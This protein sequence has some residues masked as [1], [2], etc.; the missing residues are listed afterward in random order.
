M[1]KKSCCNRCPE[2]PN[3]Q[4]MIHLYEDIGKES[5]SRLNGIFSFVLC[6]GQHY[7]AARNPI[8]VNSLYQG[9]AKDGS[10]WFASKMKY[11]IDQC[12]RIINKQIEK[13]CS[14]LS[15]YLV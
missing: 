15:A 12:D 4:V 7:M 9:C 6:D 8:G 5:I 10:V 1:K 2:S 14:I 11:L 3:D 13:V